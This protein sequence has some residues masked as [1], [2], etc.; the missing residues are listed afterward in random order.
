M[1][2]ILSSSV[3]NSTH[4]LLAHSNEPELLACMHTSCS[5]HMQHNCNTVT[6]M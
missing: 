1:T 2:W 3:I 5:I 6:M 4:L